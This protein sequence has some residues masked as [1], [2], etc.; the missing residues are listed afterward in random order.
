VWFLASPIAIVLEP[1]CMARNFVETDAAVGFQKIFKNAAVIVLTD[2]PGVTWNG[3]I[4]SPAPK[5]SLVRYND[6][7]VLKE[8]RVS[9]TK[10]VPVKAK[11][12]AD[13]LAGD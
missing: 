9:N 10:L 7:G 4:R 12:K 11:P 6:R 2:S 3:I 8:R 1:I 5:L 13:L